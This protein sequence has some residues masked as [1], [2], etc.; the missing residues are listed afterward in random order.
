MDPSS[1]DKK[2]QSQKIRGKSFVSRNSIFSSFTFRFS[3]SLIVVIVG[4]DTTHSLFIGCIRSVLSCIIKEKKSLVICFGF[5]LSL[6]LDRPVVTEVSSQRQ[7]DR[8]MNMS[9]I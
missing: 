7:R 8:R 1:F 4:K 9:K 2:E 6:S 5:S 3:L